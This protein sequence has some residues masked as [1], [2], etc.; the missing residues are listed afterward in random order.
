MTHTNNHTQTDDI[1]AVHQSVLDYWFDEL[2]DDKRINMSSETCRQWYAKEA[3]TDKYISVHFRDTYT[4]FLSS[5]DEWG[6]SPN[7]RLATVLVFDQ[8]SRNMF[9]DTPA[10][11]ATDYLA[12]SVTKDALERKLDQ[13][14]PLIGRLFLYMPLMHA[15]DS[16]SQDRMLGLFKRLAAEAK[17]VNPEN[18]GF[19]EMAIG[20]AEKHH[21][22]IGR[23]GRFPHRNSLLG[24]QCTVEE[25]KFLEE[26]Q[27]SF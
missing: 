7:S 2:S 15:E 14:L 5:A 27:S 23:F 26:N 12:L 9:R 19:F 10:M 18:V 22:I 25:L 11:H 17:S 8:F 1:S 13:R 3:T 21:A 16:H 20:F 24:R 6:S 4:H